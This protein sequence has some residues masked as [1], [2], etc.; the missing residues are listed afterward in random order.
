[1]QLIKAQ[2][3]DFER[4]CDLYTRIIGE[5]TGMEQYARWKKGLY[6]TEEG[7]RAY[8]AEGALY[9][10]LTGIVWQER[11]PL[12]WNRERIITKS[13]GRERYRI[14]MWLLSIFLASVRITSGEGS[15]GTCCAKQSSW[16]GKTIR[17][18]FDWM[19]W[20]AT[21]QP[22]ICMNPRDFG[23]GEKE[24]GMRTTRDGRIFAFMNTLWSNK[25]RRKRADPRCGER[26]TEKRGKS[27]FAAGF[28]LFLSLLKKQLT[29]D[30][31]DRRSGARSYP[32]RGMG[33]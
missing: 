29:A 5:T 30:Q 14:I 27:A 6:P 16:R 24:G 10:F 19:P 25:K 22:G 1:M 4:V 21:H 28:L 2:E 31:P 9:L 7:I 11:W 33:R 32:S 13:H 8:M 12:P 15:A 23:I 20:P 18:R 3:K 17:K 26:K